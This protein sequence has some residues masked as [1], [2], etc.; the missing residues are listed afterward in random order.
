MMLYMVLIC[1][2]CASLQV[3]TG[4]NSV[5]KNS[6]ASIV[7]VDDN[8]ICH[9]DDGKIVNPTSLQSTDGSARFVEPSH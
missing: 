8:C 6:E 4:N 2:L 5:E 3:P 7:Q 9:D 1:A